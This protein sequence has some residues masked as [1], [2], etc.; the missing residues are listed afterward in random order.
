MSDLM[1]RVVPLGEFGTA[2]LNCSDN[3]AVRINIEI[4]VGVIGV[5]RRRV[6]QSTFSASFRERVNSPRLRFTGRRKRR[7]A[8]IIAATDSGKCP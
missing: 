5:K 3:G 7:L 4:L 8:P 1:F 6:P 2:F